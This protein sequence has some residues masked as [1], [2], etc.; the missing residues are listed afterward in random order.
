MMAKMST[1]LSEHF[2]EIGEVG[3]DERKRVSLAKALESL[4]SLFGACENLRFAVYFNEAGQLLLSPKVSVPAH[5]VWLF[6]NAPAL[7][8]VTKGLTQV[9]KRDELKDLGSFAKYAEDEID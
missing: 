3:I 4:K 2:Q 1:V 8:D 7:A 9:G 5:E 6:K